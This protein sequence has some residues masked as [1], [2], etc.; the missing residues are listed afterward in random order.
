[1]QCTASIAAYVCAYV[2]V[3]SSWKR[4][5]GKNAILRA[6]STNTFVLIK[7]IVYCWLRFFSKAV[8]K[9]VRH[10]FPHGQYMRVF[11]DAPRQDTTSHS[12]M[13][14]IVNTCKNE[15]DQIKTADK[16]WRRSFPNYSPLEIFVAMTTRYLQT[17]SNPYGASDKIW[18]W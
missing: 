13:Y 1:M 14:V 10:N 18:L 3:C 5:F 6:H 8:D 2:Y 15:K 7:P 16:T 11:S 17:F 9:A 12:L 4:V